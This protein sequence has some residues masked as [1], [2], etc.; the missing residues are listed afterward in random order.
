M[1]PRMD[2]PA[3][4][5]ITISDISAAGYC[6]RG[7]K[8]WFEGY[9]INFRDV[10]RN[11]ITAGD[12]LAT[13]DAHAERVVEAKLARERVVPDDLVITADDVRKSK[14]CMAGAR[15]FAALHDL[16]YD[17]FLKQGVPAAE[18]LKH[19]D[20]NAVA[21]VRDKLGRG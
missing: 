15:E 20:P 3:G 6:A 4:L 11:G 10:I 13:G 18:L 8:G 14:K 5:I 16:D 2:A 12:L 17:R 9:G 7:A 1:M 19:G 21:V